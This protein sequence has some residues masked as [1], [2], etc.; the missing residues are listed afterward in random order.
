MLLHQFTYISAPH[1]WNGEEMVMLGD[2]DP[3]CRKPIIWD[4]IT[5]RPQVFD[6]V[7]ERNKPISV[8]PNS[9]LISYYKKLI[10]LRKKRSD[11]KFGSIEYVLADDKELTLAYRREDGSHR[12]VIAFNF[13]RSSRILRLKQ[14]LIKEVGLLAESRSGALISTHLENGFLH[15]ELSSGSGVA[16]WID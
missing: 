12:S 7:G 11:W 10:S 5:H 2:D 13:S 1:I 8:K 3:D 15:I 9:E 14:E 16:L 4:D 6:P